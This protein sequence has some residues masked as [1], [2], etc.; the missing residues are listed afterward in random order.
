VATLRIIGNV[1]HNNI[2][3]SPDYIELLKSTQ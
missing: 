3:D 2:S 1:G